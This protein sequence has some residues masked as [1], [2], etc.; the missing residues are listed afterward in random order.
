MITKYVKDDGHHQLVAVYRRCVNQQ[1]KSKTNGDVRNVTSTCDKTPREPTVDSWIVDLVKKYDEQFY[2]N[3]Y[4]TE[5]RIVS[6]IP[7][8]P[9]HTCQSERKQNRDEVFE[10]P[11]I[12][13]FFTVKKM[14][15]KEVVT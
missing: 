1:Q 12:T 9:P 13:S 2:E 7:A 5:L 14:Y 15:K 6:T 8:E 3:D 11:K 10:T 4:E